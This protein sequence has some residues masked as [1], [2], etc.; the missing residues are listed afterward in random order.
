MIM[1]ASHI[2]GILAEILIAIVIS[3]YNRYNRQTK[4]GRSRE[5]DSRYLYRSLHRANKAVTKQHVWCYLSSRL[6]GHF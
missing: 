4:L 2:Q 3:G 1:L 6:Y 5:L